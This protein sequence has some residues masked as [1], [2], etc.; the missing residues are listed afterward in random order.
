MRPLGEARGPSEPEV[1][2]VPVGDAAAGH[3]AYLRACVF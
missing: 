3:T 2:V 1:A